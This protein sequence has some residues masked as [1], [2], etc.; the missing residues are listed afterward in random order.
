MARA[1]LTLRRMR[2][3]GAEPSRVTWHVLFRAAALTVAR[4]AP[5]SADDARC[6]SARGLNASVDVVEAS[7]AAA[8]GVMEVSAPALQLVDGV[9]ESTHVDSALRED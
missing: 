8:H 9:C 2:L 4:A 6:A 3:A 7:M 1:L 5:S